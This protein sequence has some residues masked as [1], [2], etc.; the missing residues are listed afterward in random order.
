[1]ELLNHISIQ[2]KGSLVLERVENIGCHYTKA[3][4]LW[5]ENFLLHFDYK[6]RPSLLDGYPE[7][8]KEAIEVFRKKWEVRM[9]EPNPRPQRGSAADCTA[10]KYYFAYCEAGFA[11]KTLG[12]VIITVVRAGALELMEGIP[13]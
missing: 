12:D 4:R 13:L 3:L 6:I 8:S 1:M 9:V 5:R 11:T 10:P 7:M 2:S